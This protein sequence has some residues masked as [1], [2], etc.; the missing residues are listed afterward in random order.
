MGLLPAGLLGRS[1]SSWEQG[2]QSHR[3]RKA[4]K[5]F[6]SLHQTSV[7]T[8]PHSELITPERFAWPAPREVD[9]VPSGEGRAPGF[10]LGSGS[11]QHQLSTAR[12]F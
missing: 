2:R 6:C 10:S 12:V 3:E 4:A 5:A 8:Q 7:H 9:A 11:W 1:G